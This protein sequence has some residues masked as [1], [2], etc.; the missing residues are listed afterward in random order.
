MESPRTNLLAEFRAKVGHCRAKVDA[1]VWGSGGAP[2]GLIARRLDALYEAVLDALLSGAEAGFPSLIS[3]AC[4][5][6]DALPA[7]RAEDALAT[8][9]V[10]SL[11]LRIVRVIERTA[12]DGSVHADDLRWL[13]GTCAAVSDA[14]WANYSRSLWREP[15]SVKSG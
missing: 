12:R 15:R 3:V 13:E 10:R 9:R 11:L 1:I 2:R 6:D 7:L 4:A 8:P 14:A 5:M